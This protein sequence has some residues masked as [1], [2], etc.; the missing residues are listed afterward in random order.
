MTIH[1]AVFRKWHTPYAWFGRD[2]GLL[3]E[4]FREIGVP[5]RLVILETPVMS[6]DVRFLPA[7]RGQF[8][9]PSFWSA[10]GAD[11]IILQG[12]GEAVTE[13]VAEAI[14]QARIPLI[15][16]LDTDGV[17][18]PQVDP[19]LYTYNLWWWLAYHR[20][21]PAWMRAT[22]VAVLKFFFPHKLGPGRLVR[23]FSRADALLAESR[24]ACSRLRRMLFE[25]GRPELAARI[26]HMPIPI[27]GKW[28]Y[29]PETDV[30]ED[31][32]V[33]V[34]RWYDAQK[35]APKLV[36]VLSRVLLQNPGF[37]A[38]I[39]GDGDDFVRKLVNRHASAVK[40]R[41]TITGR[42]SHEEIPAHEKRAKIFI[43]S[44]R[45][46]SMNISSAEALCCG[47]SVVGPGE[48]ASMHEYTSFQSGTMAWTRR[49]AD[50]VDAVNSEIDEWKCGRR[51][52]ASISEYFRSRLSPESIAQRFVELAGEIRK[53]RA[54]WGQS[55]SFSRASG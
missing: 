39:I 11:A 38:T 41:I 13:P 12:G 30:K 3:T 47:C 50:Y 44:S 9:S 1:T 34:A 8:L 49:D 46:E 37:C 35:D 52:P 14:H 6:E 24:I 10:L 26:I 18:A 21:H 33:S 55:S 42:L 15:F 45:A 2:S 23:R 17:F 19:Y 40:Q 54:K 29:S 22:G 5:S 32:I 43:C 25:Q 36:R 51:D 4:G 48:I 53:Q 27:P 7:N 16:R 20:K 31:L 28:T